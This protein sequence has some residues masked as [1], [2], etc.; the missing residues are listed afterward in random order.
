MWRANSLCRKIQVLKR[1]F[2]PC[3]VDI[4][5]RKTHAKGFCFGHY[6]RFLKHGTAY[7]EIPLRTI[8]HGGVCT[9]PNC[10]R[11][12]KANGLC[13]GH[14]TRLT[15]TGNI[16]VDKP[17]RLIDGTRVCARESCSQLHY[18][19]GFCVEHYQKVR[20]YHGNPIRAARIKERSVPF[21]KSELI[22]RLSMYGHKCWICRDAPYEH[23]DHVK[24]LSKGGWHMLSNLRPACAR[25]NLKKNSTWP[26]DIE[27]LRHR[28]R[29]A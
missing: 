2:K 4:C 3:T 19:L 29:A 8:K 25:C 24:P 21:T 5:N 10:G 16:Q 18:A 28:V 14:M 7:P 6:Y 26:I 27:A 15:K 13:G 12:Y 17:I 23:L 22:D 9:V 20:E 1:S 11:K